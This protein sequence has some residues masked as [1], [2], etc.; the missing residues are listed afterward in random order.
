MIEIKKCPCCRD[1]AEMV[2]MRVGDGVLWQ[3]ACRRCGL[4]TDP[5]EDRILCLRQWNRRD[6][7]ESLKN[8]IAIVVLGGLVGIIV[9][10]FIGLFV[11]SG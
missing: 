3:V 11:M 8:I 1:V 10:F 4:G 5:D 2:D 7:A 6:E 9:G